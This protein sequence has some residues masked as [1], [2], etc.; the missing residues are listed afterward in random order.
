MTDEESRYSRAWKNLQRRGWIT[1]IFAVLGV[2]YTF[3]WTIG[4]ITFDRHKFLQPYVLPIVIPVLLANWYL[5]FRYPRCGESFFM[6]GYFFVWRK[7]FAQNRMNCGL[8][9][10]APRDP[11][12]FTK[13]NQ[14]LTKP[15]SRC[16]LRESFA[17]TSEWA[18]VI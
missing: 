7:F 10:N 13:P 3:L 6:Y 12:K 16:R 9:R 4:A 15:S 1:V 18:M 5:F 17:A 11:D 14:K 8:P 2:I